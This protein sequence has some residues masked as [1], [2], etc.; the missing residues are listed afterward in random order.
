MNR[1][2]ITGRAGERIPW[3]EIAGREVDVAHD[4][5]VGALVARTYPLTGS[6]NGLRREKEHSLVATRRG[7][8]SGR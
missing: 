4:G 1:G 3:A 7:K 6:I 2:E 8:R 5:V